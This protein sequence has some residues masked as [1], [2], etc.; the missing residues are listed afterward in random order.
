MFMGTDTLQTAG[1]LFTVKAKKGE[2]S[3]GT[4]SNPQPYGG[5]VARVS[6]VARTWESWI[7]REGK[8]GDRYAREGENV[9]EWEC[10]ERGRKGRGKRRGKEE[11][12]C[13]G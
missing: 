4:P 13:T 12:S 9:R 11:G 8:I 1:N 10:R 3:N 7:G 2:K 5:R 6:W